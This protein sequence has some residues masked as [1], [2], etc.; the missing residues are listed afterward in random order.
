MTEKS[1]P[2]TAC[3]SGIGYL[4]IAP[5]LSIASFAGDNNVAGNM[6]SNLE[7]IHAAQMFNSHSIRLQELSAIATLIAKLGIDS[8]CVCGIRHAHTE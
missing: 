2:A 8:I 6:Q 5:F 3:K 7:T 4:I 1:F